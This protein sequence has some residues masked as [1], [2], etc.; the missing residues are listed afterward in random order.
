MAV[1]FWVQKT[2]WTIAICVDKSIWREFRV[3]G[4]F[5]AQV[6][7]PIR[8]FVDVQ[9]PK[10]VWCKSS[11]S[12]EETA[13]CHWQFNANR[14]SRISVV[15]KATTL[16]TW[17]RQEKRYDD[18]YVTSWYGWV[19]HG[20]IL[21]GSYCVLLDVFPWHWKRLMVDLSFVWKDL[22]RDKTSQRILYWLEDTN[23][24]L[25]FHSWQSCPTFWRIIWY[26]VEVTNDRMWTHEKSHIFE[27]T[28]T[29]LSDP[30]DQY[31]NT[32]KVKEC[33]RI[34]IATLWRYSQSH[35]DLL[36][37]PLGRDW[38]TQTDTQLFRKETLDKS[39]KGHW[40]T[41]QLS[42]RRR[43][44]V[45]NENDYRWHWFSTMTEWH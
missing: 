19:A 2:R 3:F 12:P 6:L 35:L 36:E 21:P 28:T 17:E 27:I 11:L 14:P 44:R 10:D 32:E 18:L 24:Q 33:L 43:I 13:S 22:P 15:E 5:K 45:L 38:P 40:P 41:A 1:F 9:V 31:G 30:W 39:P 34:T 26:N 23:F 25:P 16:L 7:M 8:D 37:R 42:S 20:L 4:D 29:Y